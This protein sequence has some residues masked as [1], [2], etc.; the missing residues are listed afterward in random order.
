MTNVLTPNQMHQMQAPLTSTETVI[1]IQPIN[2]YT[3]R[4]TVTN[5]TIYVPEQNLQI[6]VSVENTN[7]SNSIPHQFLL[8][9][10]L[11][12][13][14]SAT[15]IEVRFLASSDMPVIIVEGPNQ[16]GVQNLTNQQRFPATLQDEENNDNA[17][18]QKASRSSKKLKLNSGSEIAKCDCFL[19]EIKKKIKSE[20]RNDSK[21]NRNL[22]ND[23]KRNK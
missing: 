12:I 14:P 21:Y 16:N 10:S 7:L 11:A 22:I 5:Q 9:C 8:M 15:A 6:Q 3:W 1:T 2:F 20:K 17:E 13:Y 23:S 4:T 19:P 18:L